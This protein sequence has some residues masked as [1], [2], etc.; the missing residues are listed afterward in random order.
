M[1]EVFGEK[2]YPEAASEGGRVERERGQKEKA[3][4]K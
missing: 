1:G 2:V 3:L 4:F